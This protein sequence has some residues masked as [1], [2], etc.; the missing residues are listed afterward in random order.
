MILPPLF[1]FEFIFPQLRAAVE[2]WT[3]EL[4]LWEHNAGVINFGQETNTNFFLYSTVFFWE[5]ITGSINPVRKP[6]HIE[7]Q[8][9]GEV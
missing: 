8:F 3:E 6:Y 4:I 5:H 7:K 1:L 9:W 2:Q